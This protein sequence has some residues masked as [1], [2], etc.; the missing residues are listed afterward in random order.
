MLSLS[1]MCRKWELVKDDQA[2]RFIN[3]VDE[4]YDRN[5][6]LVVSAAVAIQE[7]FILKGVWILNLS[8]LKADCW[9]C[10]PMIIWRQNI[11]HNWGLSWLIK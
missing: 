3:M 5:V 8:V 6:K 7:H 1:V 11:S 4:F 9:K 10:S 2:R